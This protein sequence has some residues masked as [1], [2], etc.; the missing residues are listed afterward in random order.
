[1]KTWCVI[2]LLHEEYNIKNQFTILI[3][4]KV[5]LVDLLH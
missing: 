1:V 4:L 5:A 2:D 3:G